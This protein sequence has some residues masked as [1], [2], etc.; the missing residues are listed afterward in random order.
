MAA[1]REEDA[2]A[3]L[4]RFQTAAFDGDRYPPKLADIEYLMG[5]NDNATTHATQAL[6]EREER[7]W[8]RG[9]LASTILGALL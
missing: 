8:P 3:H 1:G 2:R 7:Y 9:I 5:E 4:K 6:A